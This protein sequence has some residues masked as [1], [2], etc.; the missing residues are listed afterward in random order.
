MWVNASFSSALNFWPH[1]VR[2]AFQLS[3]CPPSI[4]M[5]RKF[6]CCA[7]GGTSSGLARPEHFEVSRQPA[8]CRPE[9]PDAV[10]LTPAPFAV[11]LTKLAFVSRDD[12]TDGTPAFLCIPDQFLDVAFDD[13]GLVFVVNDDAWLKCR[14]ARVAVREDVVAVPGKLLAHADASPRPCL[15][16][17]TDFFQLANAGDLRHLGLQFVVS[18]AKLGDLSQAVFNPAA[19]VC[20]LGLH[21]EEP[22]F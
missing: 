2:S 1:Q 14:T 21:C 5:K 18:L 11:N 15:I 6:P 10:L 8:A 20:V 17:E 22:G 19:E 16:S 7:H 4:R 12:D 3:I 13:S 9:H